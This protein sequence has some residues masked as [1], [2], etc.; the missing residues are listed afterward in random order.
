MSLKNNI[1][2]N[3][4]VLAGEHKPL[5]SSLRP[6]AGQRRDVEAIRRDAWRE[7]G[8]LTVP[9]H[10]ARLTADERAAL[11]KAGTRIYGPRLD[12]AAVKR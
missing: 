10:D 4:P 2:T 5:K 8:A 6:L 11:T 12:P 9:V 1:L 7:H 3:S